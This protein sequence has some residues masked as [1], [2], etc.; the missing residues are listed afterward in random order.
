MSTQDQNN[1]EK[2]S[3]FNEMEF[4]EISKDKL[5][6]IL[7]D[8]HLSS[9]EKNRKMEEL[10]DE[11]KKRIKDG[12]SVYY[13]DGNRRKKRFRLFNNLFKNKSHQKDARHNYMKFLYD[14]KIAKKNLEKYESGERHS[15]VT[16]NQV[17][18]KTPDDILNDIGR[19]ESDL[20]NSY[21]YKDLSLL[22]DRVNIISDWM[23]TISLANP[24]LDMNEHRNRLNRLGKEIIS[25]M[26]KL[27]K[28]E[29]R[30]R[31][32][33][34]HQLNN[35]RNRRESE[36]LDVNKELRNIKQEKHDWEKEERE[37]KQ[38]KTNLDLSPATVIAIDKELKEIEKITSQERGKPEV[39][40]DIGVMQE[41]VS[42]LDELESFIINAEG[43]ILEYNPYYDIDEK[44]QARE[45]GS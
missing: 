21:T 39:E 26:D 12:S 35:Q 20:Y 36:Q 29:E 44:N 38:R 34:N 24:D 30:E 8:K 16:D 15:Y 6:R 45:G 13:R 32:I 10:K 4:I 2:Q 23:H 11:V 43:E 1:R 17:K 5:Q 37:A 9:D 18:T 25:R 28:S 27:S 41:L 7:S 14:V 3:Y 22:L 40:R 33:E 31:A 42:K 19:V